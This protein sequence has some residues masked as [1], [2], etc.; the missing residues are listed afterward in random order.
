[1]KLA[2]PD[3]PE[4]KSC[5]CWVVQAR[6]GVNLAQEPFIPDCQCDRGLYYR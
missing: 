4:S 1:M 6:R 5:R 3:P 2:P